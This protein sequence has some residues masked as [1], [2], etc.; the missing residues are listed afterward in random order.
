MK[1][2][3][4]GTGRL[5]D[6]KDLYDDGTALI[7]DG[8]YIKVSQL[9]FLDEDIDWEQRRYEIAKDLLAAFMSNSHSNVFGGS[10]ESQAKDAVEYADALIVELK[11]I[12]T[13]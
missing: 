1:A 7:A 3:I 13:Q 12:K 10:R 4:K 6:I 11:K 9:D 5:V 2:K 8:G